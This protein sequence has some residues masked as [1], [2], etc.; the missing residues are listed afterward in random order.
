MVSDIT[1]VKIMNAASESFILGLNMKYD[2]VFV[3]S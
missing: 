1:A 2:D 3:P